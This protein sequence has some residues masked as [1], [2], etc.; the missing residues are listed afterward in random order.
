MALS[1]AWGPPGPVEGVPGARRG[2]PTDFLPAV[3]VATAGVYAL[4]EGAA[5][6]V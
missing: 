5:V 4:E 2:V 6:T 1:A 3:V